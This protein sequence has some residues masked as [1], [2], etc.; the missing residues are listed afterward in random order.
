[1]KIAAWTK[2]REA[3]K[4]ASSGGIFYEL[5]KH[6]IKVGGL[7]CGVA[8]EGT[9]PPKF[10]T[11]DKLE[12][13]KRMRGSKYLWA[14][15]IQIYNSI[16]FDIE[17]KELGHK[18]LFVGLPCQVLGLKRFLK[19]R[20]LEDDC[21]TY[22]SLR[23]HG[24]IKL[25]TFWDY[26]RWIESVT[27]VKIN[28][29]KFRD[30]N[31]GWEKGVGLGLT[32]NY[33]KS[34]VFFRPKLI[35]DYI[36]QRNVCDRCKVCTKDRNDSDITLGD[37]WG[38]HPAL[39]NRYGTGIMELNTARGY[40]VFKSIAHNLHWKLVPKNTADI[41]VDSDKIGLLKVADTKNFGNLMLSSNFIM[42]MKTINKNAKFVFIEEHSAQDTIEAETGV[43]DI[44]YRSIK[45]SPIEFFK[46]LVNPKDTN[47]VKTFADCRH[48]VILGGDY[49]TNKWKYRS[50][51]SNLVAINALNKCG[52]QV[53]V[54][55]N[56][57]GEFP[58]LLRPFVK[59]VF[60]NIK[61][62]WCRDTD[63]VERCRGI[64][65][66]KN[67]YYAPDLAFLPLHNE[68]N[69]DMVEKFKGTYCTVIVSTLWEQYANTRKEYIDGVKRFTRV[70]YNLTGKDVIVLPHST[71][72]YDINLAKDV[73]NG[74]KHLTYAILTT[75]S[76][77][78]NI[79]G[80]S[81]LNV[82]FRMHAAISSLVKGVPVVAIAYSH[83][84]KGVIAD[85]Y[86]LPELVVDK[87]GKNHWDK[88]VADI[89]LTIEYALEFHSTITR[90]INAINNTITVKDTI[91]PM[92]KIMEDK[93]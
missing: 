68:L 45:D 24:V 73:I 54:V 49:L 56:T 18:I 62:V 57:V 22:V 61:A 16:A 81:Y 2:D 19:N 58:L 43:A 21:I 42:Y 5:A 41:P 63:S 51:I 80:N 36:K 83:K 32:Y 39:K 28:N 82:S 74:E 55:S 12:D 15:P 86:N 65:V 17:L 11:A 46:R 84:Y 88:C 67:V 89:I 1:M 6:F 34:T 47:L 52:K 93:E 31:A 60:S 4:K 48:V 13:V 44:E 3:L 20:E 40:N 71:Y 30:K 33:G 50:W 92:F 38:C 70:L 75:P 69:Y 37:F 59:H 72:D 64:G 29:I 53:R 85:G 9:A 79:L 23:C 91:M 8:M 90:Q 66:T 27:K 78:R 77:A 25:K 35:K 26:M 87:F 7:V 14:N 10:F 76:G